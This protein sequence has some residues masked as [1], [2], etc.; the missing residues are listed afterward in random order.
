MKLPRRRI[1][2][3]AAGAAVLP[4]MSR[5]AKAQAY[6]N[7]FVRLVVPFP[8]GGQ[9]DIVG[10]IIGQ[11][12]SERL[13]QQFIVDN[14]PGAGGNIGTEAVVRAPTDGYTLLMASATNAI[15]ATLYDNLK[16]NFIRGTAPVASINRIPLVV[17]VHPAFPANTVSELI[18]YAKANPGKVN[19]ATPPSGTGPYMAAELFKMMAGID[20][21]LVPYRGGGPMQTD[22]LGG[23]VLVAFGSMSEALEHIK[24]GKLRALG[25]T[26][27]VRLAQLPDVPTIGETVA[28]FE[29]SGWSGIVAPRNTPVEIIARLH[30]EINA[31]LADPKIKARLT[32]VG[33]TVFATSS[34]EFAKH[35]VDETEKWAKVIKFAGIKAV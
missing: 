6:P 17:E 19:L 18:A 7:K 14:R 28:S 34:V 2:Q 1:L 13:G 15:S 29:A 21:V 31:G 30:S 24:A 33:V 3:L 32:D 26:T 23:Q 4:A 5:I 9:I 27:A 12:L 20:V 11:W 25:V 22:L 16:F 35:I 10:R 8:A